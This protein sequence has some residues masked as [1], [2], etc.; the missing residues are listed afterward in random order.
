[1]TKKNHSLPNKDL[2][3]L[4]FPSEKLLVCKMSTAL[5]S[6]PSG[7]GCTHLSAPGGWV[8]R[9]LKITGQRYRH[10]YLHVCLSCDPPLRPRQTRGRVGGPQ[11][12]RWHGQPA[13]EPFPAGPQPA[14]P[15]RGKKA[16]RYL[17]TSIMS[18]RSFSAHHK[19]RRSARPWIEKCVISAGQQAE[20][21][22]VVVH[23]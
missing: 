18:S 6:S 17:V 7:L 9:K 10:R 8:F 22:E 21:L 5:I 3:L 15:G 16:Q 13:G 4:F 12:K 20:A 14:R 2:S 1:M 23:A 19:Q 11:G